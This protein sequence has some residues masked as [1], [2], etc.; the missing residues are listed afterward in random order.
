MFLF[1]FRMYKNYQ[2][3]KANVKKQESTAKL[4]TYI[5]FKEILIALL[6]S[7]CYQ[8]SNI[9][10]NKI[11][12]LFSIFCLQNCIIQTILLIYILKLN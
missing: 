2:I 11:K 5:H 8:N 3:F 9:T 1:Y 12:K 4:L 10:Y 7:S 6:S